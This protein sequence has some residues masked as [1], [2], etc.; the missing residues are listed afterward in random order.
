MPRYV[1]MGTIKIELLAKIVKIEGNP[2]DQT[3]QSAC[4]ISQIKYPIMFGQ[5]NK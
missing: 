5:A 1:V 4:P 3:L 2:E